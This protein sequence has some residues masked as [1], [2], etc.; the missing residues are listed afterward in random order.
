MTKTYTIITTI[1]GQAGTIKPE[2]VRGVTNEE[3]AYTK[4]DIENRY[5]SR[6]D[7]VTHTVIREQ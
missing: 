7:T 3:M 4:R 1:E 2:A 6:G 5:A